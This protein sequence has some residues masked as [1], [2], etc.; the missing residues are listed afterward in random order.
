MD[1]TRVR[2]PG[3]P[4]ESQALPRGSIARSRKGAMRPQLLP[5][6]Q[7]PSIA[8]SFSVSAMPRI[9]KRLFAE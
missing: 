9:R 2:N 7:L 6:W 4:L 1:L 8:S 3:C 5:A